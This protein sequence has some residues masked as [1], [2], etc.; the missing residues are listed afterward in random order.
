MGGVQS[1]GQPLQVQQVPM[2]GV[3]DLELIVRHHSHRDSTSLNFSISQLFGRPAMWLW[4]IPGTI[5]VLPGLGQNQNRL[6]ATGLLLLAS[7]VPFLSTGKGGWEYASMD[8]DVQC[9][10]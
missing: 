2:L 10:Q 7:K 5:L 3:L 8:P 1:L 6:W 4:Y 9:L